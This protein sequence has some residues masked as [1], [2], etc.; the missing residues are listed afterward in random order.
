MGV[1]SPPDTSAKLVN[2]ASKAGVQWI[3]PNLYGGDVLNAKMLAESPY[4]Q[5]V[6]ARMKEVDE[7]SASWVGMVCGYWYEWSLATGEQWFGFDFKN[8]KVT[9][10]DD[11]KS[12]IDVSTWLQ[13]GKAVAAL[14]SLPVQ[15][16]GNGYALED[17]KNKPIFISSFKVS[18]RDML[19]S[20][21]RVSGDTDE[22]WNISYEDTKQRVEDGQAEM[23]NGDFRGFAKSMYARSFFKSGNGQLADGEFESKR[24]LDNEKLGLAKEDLDEATKRTLEMVRDGWNPFGG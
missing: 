8:K 22:D 21:H 2:A 6:L 5:S 20:I 13:C 19:D 16:E 10:Y 18:Q 3:M 7:S 15:K 11:G 4:G 12:K 1:R 17:W 9:F 14:L 23:K 24:G